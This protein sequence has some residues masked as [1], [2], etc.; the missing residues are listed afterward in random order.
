MNEGVP[1]PKHPSGSFENATAKRVTLDRYAVLLEE[2]ARGGRVRRI[3]GRPDL[4]LQRLAKEARELSARFRR[5]YHP[6]EWEEPRS[7]LTDRA[8]D[9]AAYTQLLT[10]ARRCGVSIT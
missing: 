5:W 7:D 4:R 10:E 1:T 8:A 9:V 6:T 2:A 3:L